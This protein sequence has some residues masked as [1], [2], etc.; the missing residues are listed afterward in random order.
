MDRMIKQWKVVNPK[1]GTV[2]N[3]ELW[4]KPD[5]KTYKIFKRLK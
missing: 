2:F 4:Q 1:S 3:V 5:G